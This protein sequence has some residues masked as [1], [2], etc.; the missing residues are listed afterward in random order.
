M[1]Y[2]KYVSHKEVGAVRIASVDPGADGSLILHLEGGF[3]N[4]VIAHHER[5]NKPS[6]SPGW[7]LVQYEGGHVSFSPRLVFEAGY[8]LKSTGLTEA[9][10]LQLKAKPVEEEE[11]GNAQ[12]E[13]AVAD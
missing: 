9:D 12:Q 10:G 11:T 13:H 8:T 5:M 6:P 1:E 3:D 2:P 4:V 7:Y